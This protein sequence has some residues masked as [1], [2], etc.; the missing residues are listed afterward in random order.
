MSIDVIDGESM[1]FSAELRVPRPR[2]LARRA[3]AAHLLVQRA[4]RRVPALHRP[5]L[6]AGDRPRPRRAGSVALGRR[7]R[8][9]AVV[10]RRLVRLL[11]GGDPGG[12]RPLRDRHVA[13]VGRA[14]RGGAGLL[15]LRHRRREGLRPV[16]QPDGPAAP[17]HARVRRH[18]REPRAAL[19]RD[20]L[21]AAAR[22]HRGVHVAAAVPGLQGRAAEARGARR[23]GRREVDPRVR[24]DVGEARARVPR[25]ARP[26]RDRA[27]DRA[28][29]R[30]GDPRAADVPRRRRRRLPDAR[31]RGGDAVG[32]RGAAA[33]A[34][35][36]DRLA[37]RRRALHPRRAVDRAAPAR[38]RAADRHARAAARHR[39]HGRRRRARRGD[40][41]ARRLARRHGPGRGPARRR[42]RRRGAGVEGR[43]QPQVGDG[44]VPLAGAHDRD[45]AAARRGPR[46]VPRAEGVAAQPEG[47]RR[48]VPGRQV[49]LRHGRVGLGQVDARE[50]D[51][52]QVAREP[53]EPG[54][55][56]S[57][58][59]TAASRAS[60]SSTR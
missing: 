54:A 40:D 6:A 27:A 28:S 37:A 36:A 13:A 44:A 50:R 58:A 11:R 43:A 9:R 41:A 38:Q 48:R 39:Q 51:R 56:R 59:R 52:L 16:P 7:R 17:V 25:R 42:G 45:P 32:R 29:H 2:R 55:R 4:A 31:P 15:P 35:D 24:A 46:L 21:V 14:H 20:G 53:A 57:R 47:D 19:P 34:R 12:R 18:R 49:H 33:A 10:A 30:Q 1:L 3:A 8:A 23:D 60:R 22:A 5:R 26:D